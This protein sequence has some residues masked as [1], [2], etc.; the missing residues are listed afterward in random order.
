MMPFGVP[1]TEIN[2]P[3]VHIRVV[4]PVPIVGVGPGGYRGV[5][6]PVPSVQVRIGRPYR[7]GW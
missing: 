7:P 2:V 3:G 1:I 5:V 4:P 6:I